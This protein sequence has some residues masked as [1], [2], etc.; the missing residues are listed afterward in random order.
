MK[1]FKAYITS[2]GDPSEIKMLAD[3]SDDKELNDFRK[4]YLAYEKKRK[5]NN[6]LMKE[7]IQSR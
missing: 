5:Y 2:W 4:N 7:M 3:L 1:A 6:R